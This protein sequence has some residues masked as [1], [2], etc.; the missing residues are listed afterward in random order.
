MKYR[1]TAIFLVTLTVTGSALVWAAAPAGAPDKGKPAPAPAPAAKPAPAP[2]PPPKSQCQPPRRRS[3]LRRRPSERQVDLA[4]NRPGQVRSS[5]Q[6]VVAD[7]HGDWP[8][9]RWDSPR[10]YLYGRVQVEQRTSRRGGQGR[11]RPACRRRRGSHFDYGE[12][13]RYQCQRGGAGRG[14]RCEKRCGLLPEGRYATGRQAGLQPGRLSRCRA[15]SRRVEAYHVRSG[16]G[17]RLRCFHQVGQRPKVEQGRTV[18]QL[19][20]PEGDGQRSA[21]GR[22]QGAG[23]LGGIQPAAVL[24]RPGSTAGK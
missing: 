6:V 4:A 5:R 23:R 20:D 14:E 9:R 21:R 18:Q 16:A 19:A 12:V 24:D 8:V 22:R 11:H 10:R 17:A 3:P 7:A 13:G 2:T 1:I 15:G